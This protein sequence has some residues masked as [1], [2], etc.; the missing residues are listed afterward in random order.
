M[1]DTNGLLVPGRDEYGRLSSVVQIPVGGGLRRISH[2]WCDKLTWWQ[3]STHHPDTAATNTTPF[4]VYT[5]SGGGG[6]I[7]LRHARM[8]F[9]D[10]VVAAT[11]AP[12]GNPMTDIIPTVRVNGVALA[13]SNED[14][15]SGNDRYVIDYAAGTVTF[16]VARD[17]SDEVTASFRRAGSS[18]FTVAPPTG[19]KWIIEDAEIDV[20]EDIDLT[21]EFRTVEYGS[22]P[23]LTG[24]AVVPLRTRRYK[25]V[26]DF[27]AAARRFWGPLPSGFGGLGGVSVAAWTFEWDYS[28]ADELYAT[29][30]Y[31]YNS[32]IST[33]RVTGNKTEM[34]IQ[35]DVPF[36]GSYMTVT[37]YGK[38]TTEDNG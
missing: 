38:E 3:E 35:G 33:T 36:P 30:N 20:A 29:A 34:L 2:N 12:N 37:F 16:A 15:A 21:T 13:Q 26:R 5:I 18:K 6:L 8:P 25:K 9:E 28:R 11:V 24:G 22:H 32:G 19:K 17:P 27:Q 4:L 1:P 7:D 10:D 23:T 14:A 31:L